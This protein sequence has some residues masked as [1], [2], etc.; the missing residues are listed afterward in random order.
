MCKLIGVKYASRK[1]FRIG[2]IETKIGFTV[3]LT[4]QKIETTRSADKKKRKERRKERKAS[5]IPETN[6]LI[7]PPCRDDERF[8]PVNKYGRGDGGGEGG[9]LRG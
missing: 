3:R 7:V 5:F 1:N 4:F 9:G 8:S 6:I 2:I